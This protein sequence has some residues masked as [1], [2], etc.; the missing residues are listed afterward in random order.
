MTKT[1][2]NHKYNL[3]NNPHEATDH[4]LCLLIDNTLEVTGFGI[5]ELFSKLYPL[6]HFY[7][8][9]SLSKNLCFL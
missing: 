3:L 5:L 2:I 1:T 8:L 6:I 9:Y 4:L 7:Q